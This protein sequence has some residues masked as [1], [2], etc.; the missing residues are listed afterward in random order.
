MITEVCIIVQG[1]KIEIFRWTRIAQ[2]TPDLTN[3][4]LIPVGMYVYSI[5][6]PL[7]LTISPTAILNLHSFCPID[8]AL[9]NLLLNYPPS[10]PLA[11]PW[12]HLSKT[13]V[14]SSLLC[15]HIH[16]L[17]SDW[18]RRPC[19]SNSFDFVSVCLFVCLSTVISSI[20]GKSSHFPV[21]YFV[22]FILRYFPFHVARINLAML[23][24][25]AIDYGL[26]AQ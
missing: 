12:W 3:S 19:P 15:A 13:L 18:E 21:P 20:F 25:F 1:N 24:K 6:C 4:L 5:T 10:I 9:D 8:T 26:K 16:L 17:S 22:L 14:T 2:S 11:T 7:I 23:A